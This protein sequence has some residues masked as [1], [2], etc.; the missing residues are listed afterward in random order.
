MIHDPTRLSSN[1]S[2][3]AGH[4]TTPTRH[5]LSQPLPMLS[6]EPKSLKLIRIGDLMVLTPF[7]IVFNGREGYNISEGMHL[8]KHEDYKVPML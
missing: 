7:K 2:Y 5:P 4:W 6:R 1:F 3:P 8:E